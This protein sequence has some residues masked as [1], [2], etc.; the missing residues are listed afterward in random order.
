MCVSFVKQVID[1]V[2]LS[3]LVW[4]LN[5]KITGESDEQR[6]YGADSGVPGDFN[7]IG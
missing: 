3:K 5:S 7:G 4:Y 1:R 6:V 2:F